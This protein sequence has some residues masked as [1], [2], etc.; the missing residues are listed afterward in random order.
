MNGIDQL[1]NESDQLLSDR[2]ILQKEIKALSKT[3]Q[4][5]TD[6]L[7]ALECDL[8][9]K[10]ILKAQLD[11]IIDSFEEIQKVPGLVATTNNLLTVW[12][13][14][15]KSNSDLQELTKTLKIEINDF[16]TIKQLLMDNDQ[17]LVNEIK[18][19][20]EKIENRNMANSE[21][22]VEADHLKVQ[23]EGI[24]ASIPPAKAGGN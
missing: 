9:N 17:L 12:V 3:L 21:V 5:S 8:K 10:L 7:N 15:L 19:L 4:D 6:I 20:M 13:D 24:I 14:N 2:Y 1:P 23:L 16:S 22:S 11:T 18:R